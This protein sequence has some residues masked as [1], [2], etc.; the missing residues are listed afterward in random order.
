PPIPA[1]LV[2]AVALLVE[3]ARGEPVAE[4]AHALRKFWELEG[5]VA[6]N[7]VVAELLDV[8]HADD[9]GS[10]IAIYQDAVGVLGRIWHEWF[11]ARIR[12][13]AI[14]IGAIADALP[15]LS[16][17]DRTTYAAEAER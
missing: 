3:G 6:I 12:L 9:P 8:T 13:A 10:V 4:R 2:E 16:A 7:S 11:S 1:A 5:G 15:R 14:T 17:A